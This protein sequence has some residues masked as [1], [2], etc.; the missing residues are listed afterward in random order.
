MFVNH[1]NNCSFNVHIGPHYLKGETAAY[2]SEAGDCCEFHHYFCYLKKFAFCEFIL[3]T[4]IKEV[5][6][7]R[8]K[9]KRASREVPAAA[10]GLGGSLSSVHEP[11]GS[12]PSTVT[13]VLAYSMMLKR[14]L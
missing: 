13:G 10:F 14:E 3:V 8:M 5:R 2:C 1:W 12:V 11:P 6:V 7:I 4:S 9:A